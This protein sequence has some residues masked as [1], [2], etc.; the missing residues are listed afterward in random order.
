MKSS[1]RLYGQFVI[2]DLQAPKGLGKGNK[3]PRKI[4]YLL[5]Y[6]EAF[7]R[8]GT[9]VA[10][11]YAH[12]DHETYTKLPPLPVGLAWIDG[13]LPQGYPAGP[14]GNEVFLRLG[15]RLAPRLDFAV[16]GP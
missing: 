15:Q 5:G 12:T 3:T 2:D 14:N 8:S 16:G 11:E 6:A 10:L 1:Q 9:D 4:G 7:D 13:A